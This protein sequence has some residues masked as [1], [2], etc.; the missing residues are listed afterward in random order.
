MPRGGS[1]RGEHRGNAKPKP[2][3]KPTRKPAH[4]T[5]ND[6]MRDAVTQKRGGQPGAHGAH[7]RTIEKR[8][9]ISRVI[10]GVSGAVEDMTPKE[11]MLDN[12][13]F[14]QRAAYDWQDM[15]MKAAAMPITDE[16]TLLVARC[17]AE[18]ERLRNLAT[19]H[20]YKVAPLV[21]PR[22]AAIQV[23]PSGDRNADD[24]VGALLDEVDQIERQ[25]K[26]IGSNKK[27]A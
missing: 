25:M 3:R 2:D 5:P 18:I 22:L 8:I 16:S 27:V 1:K 19:E 10:I 14:F 24:I 12:M 6:V 13:H 17:E 23:T 9:E 20:A 26:V 4:E 11:I 21:H 7:A 15:L